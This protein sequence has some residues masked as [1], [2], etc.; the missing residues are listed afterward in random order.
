M[1]KAPTRAPTRASTID[2]LFASARTSE[3]YIHN[4]GFSTHVL[5]ALPERA[6]LSF[7]ADALITLLFTLL[8]CALAFAFFP[9]EKFAE[10]VPTTIVISP[11]SLLTLT[12]LISLACGSAYWA[13]ETNRI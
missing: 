12:G 6:G 4:Q 3:P 11:M 1:N 13:S 8:G 7:W 5:A 2:D 10:L 9:S